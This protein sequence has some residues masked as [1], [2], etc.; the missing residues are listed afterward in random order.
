MSLQFES[1]IASLEKQVAAV[2]ELQDI[3]QGLRFDSLLRKQ[4]AKAEETLEDAQKG[5]SCLQD[6]QESH[7]ESKKEQKARAHFIAR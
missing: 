6:S 7:V 1:S 4:Y 3:E 5:S 2:Y